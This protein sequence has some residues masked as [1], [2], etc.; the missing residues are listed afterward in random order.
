M[1]KSKFSLMSLA[2]LEAYR[3]HNQD[4]DEDRW[5]EIEF[6]KWCAENELDPDIDDSREIYAE[7]TGATF[8]DDLDNAEREGWEH[9]MTND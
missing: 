1:K 6:R 2:Q 3:P 5:E 9:L 7:A 4:D 8:W